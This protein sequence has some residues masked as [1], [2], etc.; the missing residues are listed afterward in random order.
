[1]FLVNSANCAIKE[2][3][4]TKI[5]ERRNGLDQEEGCG[6]KPPLFKT[7][8]TIFL[9]LSY[10]KFDGTETKDGWVYIF[11]LK[12]SRVS[13]MPHSELFKTFLIRICIFNLVSVSTPTVPELS[14]LGNTQ[15]F[16]E[17]LGLLFSSSTTYLSRV[18]CLEKIFLNLN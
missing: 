12:N 1:M 8:R 7:T 13:A 3:D 6:S 4:K 17:K 18:L 11:G 14:R 2:T 15:H 9:N 10:E 5:K 16:L